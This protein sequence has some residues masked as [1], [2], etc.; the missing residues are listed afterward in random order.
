MLEEAQERNNPLLERVKFLSILSSNLDEFFMVRLAVLKGKL[1]PK[2][3]SPAEMES[4][5][6]KLKRIRA[7]VARLSN[8]AYKLFIE[9]LVPALEQSGIELSDHHSLTVDE[10]WDLD[11]YFHTEVFPLLTPLAVDQGRPFPH[12]SNL[13]MNMLVVIRDAEGQLRF[14]RVKLPDTVP[15]LLP[16]LSS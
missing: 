9:E 16:V 11:R 14:A 10:R 4:A 15:R 13:S 5:A 6:A 7:E 1:D 2:L 3:S 8:D 12:I